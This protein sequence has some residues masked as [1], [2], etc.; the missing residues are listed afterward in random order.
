MNRPAL[1]DVSQ[2]VAR[3]EAAQRVLVTTHTRADG[4]A[5]GSAA[6]LARLLA[7]RGASVAVMLHEPPPER[8]AFLAATQP[9]DVWK[10]AGIAARLKACDLLVIVD[11]CATMQLGKLPAALA[12]ARGATLAIDHHVTRDSIVDAAWV[13]ERAAACAQMIAEL[14]DAAGWPM[15]PD[16]A[17]LLFSGLAT[18][19]GW[20]R[21][22]NADARVF[23]TA[24]RLVARGARPNELY[25]RLYLN[26]P[27]ARARLLGEV[28]SSF[29]LLAGGR[30]A[31][32][33]VTQAMLQRSGATRAMT[34]DLIN[35]PQRVGSV[36]VCVL[37]VEPGPGEPVRVSLRSKRDVNTALIAAQF[38]GGGH[39]RAA[40]VRIEGPFEEVVGR[41]T[42]A[43]VR[44]L[45]KAATAGGGA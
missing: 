20:Y 8:Y 33:R 24:A 11:T 5:I 12:E 29:E 22:S 21:F 30:L 15:P 28:F 2:V 41:V 34:E 39:E 18:D 37:A 10:E 4:D 35:E 31:V 7:A 14:C 1:I 44:A 32:I 25:E 23:E 26:E 42:V 40:G 43:V 13:D 45:D 27:M 16:V 3:L 9:C 19:T 6:G 38:G 36:V 17:T